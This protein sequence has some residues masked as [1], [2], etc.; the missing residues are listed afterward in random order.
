MKNICIILAIILF[1]DK[2]NSQSTV[3]TDQLLALEYKAFKHKDSANYYIFL[4]AKLLA[5]NDQ[6]NQAFSQ[7]ARIDSYED[8]LLDSIYRLKALM[9]FEKKDMVAA[10]NYFEQCV[11]TS[12]TD[13][14]FYKILLIENLKIGTI[15][16][17]SYFKI[18]EN[19]KDSIEAAY[20]EFENEISK[21]D[22]DKYVRQA[23][24]L[25]GLGLLSQKKYKQGFIN[26][27]LVG[28][29]LTYGVL[30][31][32]HGYWVTAV[33]SGGNFGYLFYKSGSKLSNH[34]CELSH[35]KAKDTY[36]NYLYSLLLP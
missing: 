17:S 27:A 22:C 28:G 7:L 18:S 15:T 34:L 10:L 5:N 33:L 9:S 12:T 23:N 20:R 32:I 16:D 35:K 6:N 2:I 26:I 36:K 19:Q 25:P 21:L 8:Q 14:L 30:H 11:K 1:A 4:K 24:V 31:A 3:L 29:F 13:T